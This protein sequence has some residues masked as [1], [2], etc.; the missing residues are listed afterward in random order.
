MACFTVTLVAACGASVAR[1]IVAKE[2]K[3]NPYEVSLDS[4]FGVDTKWSTKLRY[5]ELSLYGGSLLL[6]GEH[7]LHGEIMPYP[8]FLSAA[9]SIEATQEMLVEMGT[10]G[11]AMLLALCFAWAIGIFTFDMI[12]YRRR[13]KAIK[14]EE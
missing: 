9:S 10:V 7:L 1:A 3:K 4:K 2:E 6:A 14:V 8:P 12:K 5:L 11:V 13:I